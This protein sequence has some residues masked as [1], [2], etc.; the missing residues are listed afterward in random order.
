MGLGFEDPWEGHDNT[1]ETQA[2]REYV[3][4]FSRP[5]SSVMTWVIWLALVALI[6]SA[7]LS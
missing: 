5:E 1:P 6:V 3:E 4:S 2:A 7:W